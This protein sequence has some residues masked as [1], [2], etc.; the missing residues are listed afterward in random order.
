MSK[1]YDYVFVLWG[2]E[3]DEVSATVFVTTLREAGLRVKIVGL[4]SQ[5]MGG[6]H[7]LALIPDL[8]LDQA[9]PLAR[10]AI[11]LIIPCA[12]HGIRRLKNDPRLRKFCDRAYA[13]KAKFILG[14]LSDTEIVD[15]NLFSSSLTDVIIYPESENLVVFARD[16]A[17]LLSPVI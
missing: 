15:L 8:T 4:S 5:R 13:N 10:K 2:D 3:F 7:G 14:Q 9:L 1:S 12:S 17:G 6:V 11:C 16:V